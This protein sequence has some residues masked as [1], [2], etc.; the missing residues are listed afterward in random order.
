MSCQTKSKNKE[1][2][3]CSLLCIVL[4]LFVPAMGQNS[5]SF[6]LSHVEL[7]EGFSI[8]IFAEIENAR[9]LVATD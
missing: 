1:S 6:D 5:S 9:S 7:P 2:I 3:L 4:A 8:D